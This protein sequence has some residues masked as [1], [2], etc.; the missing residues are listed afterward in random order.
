MHASTLCASVSILLW[1]FIGMHVCVD[2]FINKQIHSFRRFHSLGE[3]NNSKSVGPELNQNL[4]KNSNNTLLLRCKTLASELI[5]PGRKGQARMGSAD[6]L[7]SCL[8][9]SLGFQYHCDVRPRGGGSGSGGSNVF[10]SKDAVECYERALTFDGENSQAL[11]LMAMLKNSICCH[12]LSSSS[13]SSDDKQY[14]I[15]Q[16]DANFRRGIL[17]TSSDVCMGLASI[18]YGDF[19]SL[20]LGDYCRAEQYY[21]DAVRALAGEES[22]WVCPIIAL[23]SFYSNVIGDFNLAERLLTSTLRDRHHE[24]IQNHIS[25]RSVHAFSD[26]LSRQEEDHEVPVTQRGAYAALYVASAYYLLQRPR[27][28]NDVPAAKHFISAALKIHKTNAGR[29]YTE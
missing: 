21:E 7:A 11:I 24:Q 22:L 4:N 19:L 8:L 2:I 26:I 9:H 17:V 1:I 3:A 5:G 12:T 20:Q 28:D 16:I 13:S 27:G 14:L 25:N 29:Q 23:V 15:N 10:S 18:C 6:R